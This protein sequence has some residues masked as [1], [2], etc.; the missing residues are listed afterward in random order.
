[1]PWYT[2]HRT[3]RKPS[4]CKHLFGNGSNL[5]YDSN[6]WRDVGPPP[7]VYS[8]CSAI[9]VTWTKS[10]CLATDPS[11]GHKSD[12][13]PPSCLGPVSYTGGSHTFLPTMVWHLFLYNSF[14]KQ[15]IHCV[16]F[17]HGGCLMPSQKMVPFWGIQEID[18]RMRS[19]LLH[20]LASLYS[21]EAMGHSTETGTISEWP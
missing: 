2:P 18:F 3:I 13:L 21:T 1:M 5:Q 11:L 17:L 10:R 9:T 19:C 8:C 16:L 20:P 6:K 7:E 14:R 12:Y 4:T 15:L